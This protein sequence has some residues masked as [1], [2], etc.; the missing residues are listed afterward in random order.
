[1]LAGGFLGKE[2][3]TVAAAAAAVGA[4]VA[5]VVVAAAAAATAAAG[6]ENVS[7]AAQEAYYSPTSKPYSARM[8]ALRST[9][10]SVSKKPEVGGNGSCSRGQK[11]E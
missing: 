6:V 9:G 4:V 8:F 2:S 3:L 10:Y 11:V 5:V 7:A 1:M